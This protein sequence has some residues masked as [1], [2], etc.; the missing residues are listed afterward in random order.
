MLVLAI[1]LVLLTM[2]TIF[3]FPVSQDV[4]LELRRRYL[5]RIKTA[6]IVES[7]KVLKHL[8]SRLTVRSINFSSS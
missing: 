6:Y 8:A 1:F 5:I 7:E 2:K 3:D 4:P